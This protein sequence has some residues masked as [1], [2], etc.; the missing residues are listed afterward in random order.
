MSE[1]EIGVF[2]TVG[3]VYGTESGTLRVQ[4]GPNQ[5][6][7]AQAEV[8]LMLAD[9]VPE[10]L[11]QKPR[12]VEDMCEECRASEG[13]LCHF[14]DPDW[15]GPIHRAGGYENGYLEDMEPAQPA[16]NPLA[17]MEA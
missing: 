13:G 16:P 1:G 12:V 8:V 4:S 5:L 10:A 14:H 17:P 11:R 9:I 3:T 2:V 6:A 7:Q 15:E